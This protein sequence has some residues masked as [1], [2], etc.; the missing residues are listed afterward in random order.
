MA[1]LDAP[2]P[3]AWRRLPK[4]DDTSGVS[5]GS[6]VSGD[7][8]WE[9]FHL[10]DRDGTPGEDAEKGA[11]GNCTVVYL[12]KCVAE[13]SCQRGCLA[14]GAGSYRWFYDGCCECVGPECLENGSGG[15]GCEVCSGEEENEQVSLLGNLLDDLTS[16]R[17]SF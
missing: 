12:K 16:S 11:R 17:G 5:G 10:R 9:K 1:D 7:G 4:R 6:G 2:D 14:M 13:K 15:S 8:K 3:R